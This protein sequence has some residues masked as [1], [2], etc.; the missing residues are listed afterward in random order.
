[1][2]DSLIKP[3][4][5]A[6]AEGPCEPIRNSKLQWW[7]GW[8]PIIILPS[9]VVAGFPSTLPRWSFMWSLSFAI[10]AGCKWLTWRR[11]PAIG[12]PLWRHAGYLFAWPGMDAAAFLNSPSNTRFV[13]CTLQEWLFALLKLAAGAILFWGVARTIP[14]QYPY[15]VGWIGMISTVT[16]L[17]FGLF[18]LLSCGWR[19]IHVNARP[20]MNWP[21]TSQNIG[22][23]WGLRWNT[24]FRDLTHRFLFQ[25]LIPRLG[26]R[27]AVLA[28]FLASGLVHD[29]VISLPA[30]GGY[31][32][33][34]LFFVVQ[35]LA[36]LFS[37]TA[38]ARRI[39]LRTGWLGW[40]F[41][42]VVI[43]LP[44]FLLFHRAFVCD[45]IVPFMKSAGA[46]Q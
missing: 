1:M 26:A 29:L 11:T 18:H 40:L 28:G 27:G 45:V 14:H 20:L 34:T 6:L 30:G 15:L 16:M 9:M 2:A 39:G 35:G 32:G 22:E 38:L 10:Y 12:V 43:L 17:H 42:L 5:N 24:A 13:D 36:I 33:P 3:T 4:E 25:P 41:T 37:R 7:R 46:I 23:F 8:A 19:T 31:G 21:L 44:V